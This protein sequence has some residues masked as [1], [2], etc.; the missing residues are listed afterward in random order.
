MAQ[1][2]EIILRNR[3]YDRKIGNTIR[4]CK[5]KTEGID[6]RERKSIRVRKWNKRE[7]LNKR[8]I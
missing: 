4:K 5:Q 2:T 8:K 1:V 3:K 7:E 6:K